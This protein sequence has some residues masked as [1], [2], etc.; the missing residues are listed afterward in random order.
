MAWLA[1]FGCPSELGSLESL[2]EGDLVLVDL[3]ETGAESAPP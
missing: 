2:G 3:A 1:Q